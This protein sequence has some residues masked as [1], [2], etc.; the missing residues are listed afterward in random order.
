[1]E[2]FYICEF[3]GE[4]VRYSN[5]HHLKKCNAFNDFINNNKEEIYHLYYDEEYSMNEL[6]DYFNIKYNHMQKVFKYL[7]WSTRGLSDSNNTKRVKNKIETTNIKK[8]GVSNVLQKESNIRKKIEERLL[9]EEGITNVFQRESVK[10]KIKNTFKE[11]YSKE[12]IY[13]NYTKGSTLQYWINKLGEKEGKK[14]YKRIC[15]EK[16]KANQLNY[17]IEL[18]GENEGKRLF[19]ERIHE[20]LKKSKKGSKTSI[21]ERVAEILLKNNI[22]FSREHPLVRENKT[23]IFY[24]DFLIENTLH[25]ELNGDFWHANPKFYKKND[26]LHFPGRYIHAED[27]W[28]KDEEKKHLSDKNGYKFLTL[29]ESDLRK[30]E[31]DQILNLIKNELSKD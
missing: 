12:E 26:I 2:N 8:Y 15:S 23:N 1:M 22:L 31:N 17:Y 6:S 27:L 3:C 9:R 16:G 28:K 24:Y 13:Y 5:P 11:K 21:N 19:R 14:E 4:K 10:Q 18:Y 25:L 20:R 7:K 30:L 29:W